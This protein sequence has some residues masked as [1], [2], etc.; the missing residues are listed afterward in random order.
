MVVLLD[1]R[2]GHT[3]NKVLKIGV[4]KVHTVRINVASD[5]LSEHRAMFSDLLG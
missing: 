5:D 2:A 1:S 4:D 3:S